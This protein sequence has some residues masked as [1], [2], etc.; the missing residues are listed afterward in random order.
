MRGMIIAPARR[1]AGLL[2]LPGDKSISHRAALLAAVARGTTTISNFLVGADCLS[3]LSCLQQLGVAIERDGTN[4]RVRG[5]TGLS[6]PDA[7]LDCG[8]S[9]STIRMLT[10][11]L[12]SYNFTSELTG[13][14]SLRARPMKRIIAPLTA[15][16]AQ[17]ESQNGYAPLRLTG[18]APL[19]AIN[20][21]TPVASAQVKSCV[22]L[23]GLGANGRTTVSEKTT[24][25]DH[26]ERMLQW[27]GME[28]TE[29]QTAAAHIV[30][31]DGPARLTARDVAVPGDVSSAAF[32]LVAA[33]LLPGSELVLPNVGLNPTRAQ[34]VATLRDL[35]ADIIVEDTREEA[36]EPIGTL[37]ARGRNTLAPATP[38]ANILRGATVAQMIDEMPALAVL[39]TQIEGGLTVRDAAELRVKESD[40]IAAIVK[41]LR[42]MGVEVEEYPDGFCVNGPVKLQGAQLESFGDHR[43][44]MAFSIAALIAAGPSEIVGA[45]CAAVSFPEF[46]QLLESVTQR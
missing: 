37:R 30:S 19:T 4:V 7:P 43:I 10:G 17:I 25:R 1:V 20:Y 15:M 41:N 24:T 18:C 3:T 2:P 42:A 14:E 6:A 8:N 32:F 29:T 5:G 35:G 31:I 28:V 23:A 21:E 27:F 44:A 39:G 45:D 16:G 36:N 33:A 22:L 26:T 13:D 34:I 38:Q 40:R 12:A 11:L 9:G 46:F